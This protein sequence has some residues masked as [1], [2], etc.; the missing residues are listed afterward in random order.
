M[1]QQQNL[2]KL[3]L[4]GWTFIPCGQQMINPKVLL[5]YQP[6]KEH[7]HGL[8]RFSKSLVT[9]IGL[10]AGRSLYY[11]PLLIQKKDDVS[12]MW[13]YKNPKFGYFVK[14]WSTDPQNMDTLLD[15]IFHEHTQKNFGK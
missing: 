6:S 11:Q 14:S 13:H 8:I 9:G 10:Y 12:I 5:I 7:P 15:Y 1:E 2:S 3:A 4:E